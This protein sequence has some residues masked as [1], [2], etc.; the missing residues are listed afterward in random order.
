VRLGDIWGI[1]VIYSDFSSC[2][3]ALYEA[4]LG[5]LGGS[6]QYRRPS[7]CERLRP[8]YD[9]I[10]SLCSRSVCHRYRSALCNGKVNQMD[11]ENDVCKAQY[12]V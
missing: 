3:A 2:P 12:M 7:D 6:I 11:S 1:I 9:E 4:D 10:P 8:K 5:R